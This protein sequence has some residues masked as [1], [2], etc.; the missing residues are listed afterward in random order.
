MAAPLLQL[1]DIRQSHGQ[2]PL[3]EQA[4]LVVEPGQ[5]VALVGR[6]G[7]GKST[8]LKIA[9]GLLEPDRGRVVLKGGTTVRYLSQEP[10]LGR[11]AT[12]LEAAEAG[13]VAGQPTYRAQMMLEELG[14]DP[15]ADPKTLSG[16]EQR[17]VALAQALAPEPELL[18]L[19]EPTNHLDLPAIE[20]LEE[21]LKQGREA[22]VLVSHDRRFLETLT[23]ATVWIDRGR[24]R[25]LEAGFASFEGWRD[26]L[27]E[28]EERDA[29]KLAR[30]LVA[31]EHWRRYGVTARRKRNQRRMAQ[32]FQ[33]RQ[34]LKDRLR[35]Q[36]DVTLTAN[37]QERSGG[38]VLEAKGLEKSLGGKRLVSDFSLKLREGDR[39]AL[40]GANGIGKTTLIKLLTGALAP[41][42]GS[43]RLGARV[44]PATLDQG[45]SSLNPETPLREA[46]TAGEGDS[47]MVA[48][49]PRHVMSYLEDFLFRPEQANSPLKVLSGGERGRLMLARALALPANLLVLDEPT[50]DLDLETLDLLQEMLADYAGTVLLVSHDRDFIDR[51]ATASVM[52]EGDGHWTL[53][54]GGYSD[55]VAQ[56]GSGVRAKAAVPPTARRAPRRGQARGG[57]SRRAPPPVDRRAGTAEDPAAAHRH[58]GE[59]HRAAA[60]APGGR[61]L[62]PP[63]PRGLR[64]SRPAARHR[65]KGPGR[66]RGGLAGPGDEARGDRGGV[67][68]RVACPILTAER[69][70]RG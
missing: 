23:N 55:M 51:V 20:W 68:P 34:Q 5:R 65:R 57:E 66:G 31:E 62:L 59:G 29:H 69:R 2:R 53:Y 35:P 67:T 61:R 37:V 6:N 22:L 30:K 28:E 16:G 33:I 44:T 50:N 49:K 13:F 38:L 48:G 4:E 43:I 26:T 56:R 70:R 14:V 27:L 46:L 15:A 60:R 39:L 42:A 32:L 63:R 1:E 11:Y 58:P 45:R 47:V 52:A 64:Q 10:D 40:I 41:D 8:L 7:S 19:D 21:R 12:A 3:L 24:T 36:G 9:A 18:L 25:R 54:A 17:R